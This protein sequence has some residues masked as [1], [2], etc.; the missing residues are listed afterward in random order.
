MES[1]KCH[2][3]KCAKCIW[4]N[5]LYAVNE[6]CFIFQH[7][8]YFSHVH[9]ARFP[10]K[11]ENW[12]N[13]QFIWVINQMTCSDERWVY[14]KR[15]RARRNQLWNGTR[16]YHI[17]FSSFQFLCEYDVTHI[18]FLLICQAS[19]IY[20][21]VVFFFF[22]IWLSAKEEEKRQ[23][24]YQT[25][26]NT[27]AFLGLTLIDIYYSSVAIACHPSSHGNGFQKL[28]SFMPFSPCISLEIF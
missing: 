14:W 16:V 12:T 20:N 26:R 8:C 4:C 28:K 18:I 24:A 7:F 9:R 2:V 25:I 15:T 3:Y 6:F 22:S 17:E 5:M 27:S 10:N 1:N 23:F 11:L 21:L 19:S 13:D